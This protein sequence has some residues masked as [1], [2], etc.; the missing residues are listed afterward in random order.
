MFST[1][2]ERILVGIKLSN[3]WFLNKGE[4]YLAVGGS[5]FAKGES[6]VDFRAVK[7]KRQTL[8]IWISVKRYKIVSL[9]ELSE[10][11]QKMV[12]SQSVIQLQRLR[13]P[14]MMCQDGV[15]NEF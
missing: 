4:S 11:I 8:K 5:L 3:Y 2:V 9:H 1:M 10:T 13:Q 7:G 14:R 6:F 12:V 15:G